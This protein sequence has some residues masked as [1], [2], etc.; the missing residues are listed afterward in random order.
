MPTKKI[1]DVIVI[2][3][4]LIL[5]VWLSPFILIGVFLYFVYKIQKIIIIKKLLRRVKKE[6]FPQGKYIFFL[7][8]NSEKWK[9]YFEKQIIPK[10]HNKAVVWNWSARQKDGWNENLL[11]AKILRQFRPIGYFY[12]MAIVFL[13]SGE[14]K[15]F[16]F[17]YQYIKMLKSQADEYNRLEKKFFDTVEAI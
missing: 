3:I 14:V 10:L 5:A 6:W 15:V 17:Y 12:P 2:L 4:L 9:V 1:T 11:E 16:S 8:S 7:Y 13:L